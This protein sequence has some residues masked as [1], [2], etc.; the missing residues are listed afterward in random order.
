MKKIDLYEC[1]FCHTRYSDKSRAD[2]CE[3]SHKLIKVATAL[4]YRSCNSNPSGYPDQ[5][6][7]EFSDGSEVRYVRG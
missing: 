1:E 4:K 5:I 6:M 7:V 2:E 3:K